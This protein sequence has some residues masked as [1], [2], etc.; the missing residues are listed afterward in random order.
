M[1]LQGLPLGQLSVQHA[2][3]AQGS[4]GR[5]HV[6]GASLHNWNPEQKPEQHSDEALH[7][8]QLELHVPVWYSAA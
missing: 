3:L 4:Q 7:I 5:A 1:Q 2:V 8:M 6:I